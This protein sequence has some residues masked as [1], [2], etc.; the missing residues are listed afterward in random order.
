MELKHFFQVIA[1]RKLIIILI[2]V[3]TMI[4]VVVGTSYTTPV[5]ESSTVVRIAAAEEGLLN[6]LGVTYA[7]RLMNTYV[8]IITSRPV[9][10]ELENRLNLSSDPKIDAEAIT[11]TELIRITVSGDDPILTTNVAN[12]LSEILIEESN[13][14][15]TGGTRTSEDIWAG[16]LAQA[17]N[18]LDETQKEYDRLAARPTP[19]VQQLDAVRQ[20]LQLQQ[21]IYESLRSQYDLAS[22]REE[23]QS[24]MVTVVE[25]SIIP[26]KPISPIRSLNYALGIIFGLIVGIVLALIFENLDPTLYST[27]SI[28]TI[29]GL[30]ALAKI[31]YTKSI[32]VGLKN[33]SS[34]EEAFRGLA[35]N[36]RLLI[37]PSDRKVLAIISAEPQQGKSSLISNLAV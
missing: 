23:M 33:D 18:D 3:I 5:Y 17:K 32:E 7:Q 6:Y 11:N 37:H 9:L 4:V 25:P 36:L 13:Q 16:Y 20:T 21:N 12:T 15:Y 24:A 34:L 2:V 1:R 26:E 31:P 10:D 8:E 35:S 19:Q 14:F 27:Q 29:S 22:F 30:K 28:E